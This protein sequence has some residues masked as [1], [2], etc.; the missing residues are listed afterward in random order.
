M[1]EKLAAAV[2]CPRCPMCDQPPELIVSS[3][4]WAC[5]TPSCPVL[6]WSPWSSRQDNLE[7]THTVGLEEPGRR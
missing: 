3:S 1:S 2:L 4:Q 6:I 5:S 7:H